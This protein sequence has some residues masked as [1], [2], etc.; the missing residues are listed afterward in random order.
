MEEAMTLVEVAQAIAGLS[1]PALLVIIVVALVK[2]WVIPK[3]R[4]EDAVKHAD[5]RLRE[6]KEHTS[7]QTKLLAREISD[8]IT[9]G[10][11][12]A[13]ERG[14]SKGI[15]TAVEYLKNGGDSPMDA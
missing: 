11:E 5:D 15:V 14:T 2:E 10:T 9:E 12:K 13:V 8:S 4:H 7:S 3:G 6:M 1:V